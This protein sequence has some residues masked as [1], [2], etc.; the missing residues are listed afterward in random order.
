MQ[1]WLFCV[2]PLSLFCK[3][4]FLVKRFREKIS[5]VFLFAFLFHCRSF[6]PW[7]WMFGISHS[8]IAAL[9]FHVFFQRNYKLF[10]ISTSSSFSVIHVSVDIKIPSKKNLGFVVVFSPTLKVQVAMRFT[11]KTRGWLKCKI[12]PR[13]TWRGVRTDDF[14]RTNISWIHR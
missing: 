3:W 4:N 14:V 11:A 8:L 13:L 12:S 5:H 10:I 2:F 1:H 7:S 9:I 6:S